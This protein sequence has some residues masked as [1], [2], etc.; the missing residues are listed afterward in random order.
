MELILG[1][2]LIL[3][4]LVAIYGWVSKK[5]RSTKLGATKGDEVELYDWEWAG[6][7][8]GC[9]NYCNRNCSGCGLSH[10]CIVYRSHLVRLALSQLLT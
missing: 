3:A 1:L 8:L 6:N 2:V 4:L 5:T 9:L 10:I 7:R